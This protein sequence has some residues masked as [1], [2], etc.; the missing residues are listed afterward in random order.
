MSQK[1]P[2]CHHP[3]VFSA[4]AY[5]LLNRGISE[6]YTPFERTYFMLGFGALIFTVMA[7]FSVHGDLALYLQP[8]EEKSYLAAILFLSVCC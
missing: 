5:T 1:R 4:V 8:F 3:A 7:A 2:L 6:Q